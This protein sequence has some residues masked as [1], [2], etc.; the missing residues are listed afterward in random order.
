LFDPEDISLGF[1]MLLVRVLR[2]YCCGAESVMNLG[3]ERSRKRRS[4][5][6]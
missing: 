3:A 6:K 2:W 1:E 5:A 4:Y